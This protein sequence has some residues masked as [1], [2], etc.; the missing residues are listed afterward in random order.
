MAK[1]RFCPSCGTPNKLEA[2]FCSSC[3]KDLPVPKVASIR[4]ADQKESPSVQSVGA[5]SRAQPD[6]EPKEPTLMDA[7]S[8]RK[9]T[10]TGASGQ[11]AQ[12]T[13]ASDPYAWLESRPKVKKPSIVQDGGVVSPSQIKLYLGI[14]AVACV[15]ITALVLFA[16]GSST[17]E[18]KES[19]LSAPNAD[20]EYQSQLPQEAASGQSPQGQENASEA[21]RLEAEAK[22]E[23]EQLEAFRLE[24]QAEKQ[25]LEEELAR[26]QAD[27]A[28]IQ[29]EKDAAIAADK[30]RAAQVEQAAV[31]KAQPKPQPAQSPAF[32][33]I[34]QKARSCYRAQDYDC[35]INSAEIGLDLVPKHKELKTIIAESQRRQTE[36][37][38]NIV[39][40]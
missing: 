7:G 34:L 13:N 29:A 17:S 38:N 28:R 22:I 30:A 24:A 33:R 20:L 21:A 2:K 40:Q 3:G 5:Q 32:E 36:A 12:E 15:L 11:S 31:A 10:E 6:I 37:L 27:N 23:A 25:R 19:G 9:A 1:Q 18:T 35:A 26:V 39:I 16:T 8:E 14:A 4:T